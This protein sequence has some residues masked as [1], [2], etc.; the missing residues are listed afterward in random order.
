MAEQ[1][2][3]KVLGVA[4]FLIVDDVKQSAE[5]YRD[6]L[7]FGFERLWGEPPSFAMVRRGAVT[8][9]LKQL[10]E[11]GKARPNVKADPEACWDAYVWVKEAD[12]LLAEFK[13]KGV[14]VVREIE[15]TYYGCRDFDI[16]DLNGY[17]LCF[18]Q[19]LEG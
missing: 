14:T 17:I 9:M 13:A 11:P 8:L 19:D 12:A 3:P 18:G 7:G 1:P 4:P 5:W 2:G 15:N 6:I 16:R 10:C